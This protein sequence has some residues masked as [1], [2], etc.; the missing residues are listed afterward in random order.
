VKRKPGEVSHQE[1]SGKA[2]LDLR[3][4][5]S[6]AILGGKGSI[7]VMFALR[8]DNKRFLLRAPAETE[9]KKWI[10]HIRSVAEYTA[11]SAFVTC[12]TH[13]DDP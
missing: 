7:P 11:M 10:V 3:S 2:Y 12:S 5:Q 9:M 4:C 13:P 1:A 6:I 8:A